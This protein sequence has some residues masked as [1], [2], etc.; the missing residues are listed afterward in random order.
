MKHIVSRGHTRPLTEITFV[1]DGPDHTFL[2]S[3]AHDKSPQIRN[4]ETGDWIG[5]FHGHKGAVWSAKVDPLTR[6]LAATA[7]GDFTAKLWC[8]T[9]AKELHE[10]KH[11]HVVKS[12]DFS[13]DSLRIGTGCQDGLLRVYDTCQ[14][15]A[16]PSEFK[17]DSTPV[18]GVSKIGWSKVDQGVAFVAKKNGVVEKWDTRVVS[19]LPVSSITIA[20]GESVMDFEQSVGLNMLVVASGKKVCSYTLD[21]LQL[22]REYTM[23]DKMT[24]KEEGGVSLSPDGSKF[25]AGASDLWLRE[26]DVASG[27]VLRTFKGHHGPIRC[28]RYHPGGNVGASGSEDGTIRLWDLAY[29]PEAAA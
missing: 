27:D 23:P 6:T 28:V 14:P 13:M 24:F 21:T 7:S 8:A 2:V 12:V 15:S 5:T 29:D 10:F 17:V 18:V 25:I 11:K 4:G 20:G 9:T 22:L 3:S 26:F 19:K 1:S 16:P